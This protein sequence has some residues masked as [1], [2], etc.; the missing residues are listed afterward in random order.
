MKFIVKKNAF[1]FLKKFEKENISFAKITTG[2]D[3]IS[4]EVICFDN[5][6]V[7]NIPA[8]ITEN[9]SVFMV[10][11]KLAEMMERFSE[12]VV[13]T[14]SKAEKE[15]M[16]LSGKDDIIK[17]SLTCWE[18][19]P[20]AI[21]RSLASESNVLFSMKD[22]NENFDKQIDFISKY[23]R[24]KSNVTVGFS[25]SKFFYLCNAK[26]GVSDTNG[27]TKAYYITDV[28]LLEKEIK[29]NKILDILVSPTVVEFRFEDCSIFARCNVIGY[30]TI[31]KTVTLL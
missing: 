7:F 3:C 31:T 27:I 25:E 13:F 16:E 17:I 26:E 14:Y 29:E 21:T 1:D 23:F 5:S 24:E 15:I 10:I 22:G 28:N 30:P 11:N 8:K 12:D 18:S 2:T 6:T 19:M 9:G 4:I 20:A